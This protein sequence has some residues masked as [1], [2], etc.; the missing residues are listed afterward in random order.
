[1]TDLTVRL[2]SFVIAA[3]R[4]TWRR[5]LIAELIP[6]AV[7]AVGAAVTSV[8]LAL[9]GLDFIGSGV[10]GTVFVI[11][12]LYRVHGA[13][14]GWL[15]PIMPAMLTLA[16][17]SAVSIPLALSGHLSSGAPA[18][19]VAVSSAFVLEL[20]V[21]GAVIT[22]ARWAR[23]RPATQ[24]GGLPWIVA[25]GP[26]DLAGLR[27]LPAACA[28]IALVVGVV[29][30]VAAV[31]AINGDDSTV[32]LL[33]DRGVLA[34]AVAGEYTLLPAR[35]PRPT[36][37]IRF[38]LPG[39]QIAM[40]YD[41]SFDGTY[42]VPPPPDPNASPAVTIR[43]D[44]RDVNVFLPDAVLRH[45]AHPRMARQLEVGAGLCVPAGALITW[46]RIRRRAPTGPSHPS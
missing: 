24:A 32:G 28:V 4:L 31:V 20:A 27:F 37:T 23:A 15:I 13:S 33:R 38:P 34:R 14:L 18:V 26:V 25:R 19:V 30:V 9:A 45:P 22:G 35:Y 16:G 2:Q 43:Y 39:G 42:S 46:R 7:L 41:T 44:P 3:L 17:D 29:M 5:W 36:V 6:L 12:Y 10:F 40:V 11:V 21:A 8:A 1:M